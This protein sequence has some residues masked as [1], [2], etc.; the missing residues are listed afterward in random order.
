[1]SASVDAQQP[2]SDRHVVVRRVLLVAKE[3]VGQPQVVPLAL[4][5]LYLIQLFGHV[6][7][8]S[9]LQSRVSPRLAQVQV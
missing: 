2:V 3:R 9:E 8:H 1:M 7:R 4:R 6:G 5:H